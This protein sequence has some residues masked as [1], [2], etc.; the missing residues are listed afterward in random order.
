V[1]ATSAVRRADLKR[2]GQLG[3][4]FT[5]EPGSGQPPVAHDAL[6]GDVEDLGCF[7]DGQS[8]EEAQ[9]DLE[10]EP[11]SGFTV[12]VRGVA[13][14][15]QGRH[16]EAI[17]HMQRAARLD[18]SL[19][20]LALQAHVLAVANQRAEALDILRQVEQAAKHRYFCPYEIAT[21]YVSLGDND[22][23]A[24]LFRKGTHERADC[25]AWLGVEPWIE[26]FRTDARYPALL[27]D[28]GLAP[29]PR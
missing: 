22:R 4:Q 7:V 10:L 3:P 27:R 2:S 20:I 9:L 17:E 6:R 24:K 25:M 1:T 19:T 13:Y 16:D 8:S 18:K 23:A 26:A 5:R 14:A 11:D 28:I 12:P 15:A 29:A 21:V